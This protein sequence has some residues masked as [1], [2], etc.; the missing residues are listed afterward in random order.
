MIQRLVYSTTWNTCLS[1][2]ILASQLILMLIN[3]G[4]FAF[5]FVFNIMRI[6]LKYNADKMHS[7]K[8]LYI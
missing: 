4:F 8:C 6:L 7:M 5:S 1:K 2:Y 3:R